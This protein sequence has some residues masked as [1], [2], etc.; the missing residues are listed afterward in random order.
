MNARQL[1]IVVIL[2][3]LM[4]VI[5]SQTAI[6]IA[7]IETVASTPTA[8]LGAT[9][10]WNFYDPHDASL[11]ELIIAADDAYQLDPDWQIQSI[12]YLYQWWGLADPVFNYQAITRT[13]T[14]FEANG[15]P[16]A[17][18]LV[19]EFLGRLS[20]LH[21]SQAILVGQDHTDDYPSWVL[22]ITG[23]DGQRIQLYSSSTANPNS[24]PWNVLSN[25]RLYAQYDGSMGEA[26][27]KLFPTEQGIPGASFYPGGREPDTLVFSTNGFPTQLYTGFV[28]LLPV[29]SSFSYHLDAATGELKGFV[30][31][32]S[33]I[34]E[35]GNMV[36]GTITS[37]SRVEVW[38]ADGSAV[39]CRV[40]DIP[41]NDPA[42]ARWYFTCM[43]GPLT[44]GQ[45]YH[46]PIQMV[47][48][49][50]QGERVTT[51]G[52]L[53]GL[54]SVEMEVQYLLPVPPEILTAMQKDATAKEFVAHHTFVYADYVA[55]TP[56]DEWQNGTFAGEALFAGQTELLG[57]T[58]RYTVGTPF[59]IEG[60]KLTYWSASM[61]KIQAMLDEIAAQALTRRVVAAVP[62]V[63]INLW[64]AEAG[65]RPETPFLMNAYP[66]QY[67]LGLATCGDVDAIRLPTADVPLR[68]FGFN[69]SWGFWR[70]DF[71]L[72]DNKVVVGSFDFWPGD[73]PQDS[74]SSLLLP[75][76][77]KIDPSAQFERIWVQAD[78]WNE[79]A[80]LTLYVPASPTLEQLD[81]YNRIV[82]QLPGLVNKQYETM[83]QANGLTFKVMD[84][85]TLKTVSCNSK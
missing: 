7:P 68:S 73:D 54:V 9:G 55:T 32:R 85:G 29:S 70:G 84:D 51:E 71:V 15:E 76:E 74:V 6:P 35:M 45:P 18:A 61:S 82:D 66:S 81:A 50:D 53:R 3:S 48:G 41:T 25:G 83:W 13:E 49:T 22:E 28:G 52:E 62:D 46:Y 11:P 44:V 26:I 40:D 8:S 72:L 1:I 36:I 10:V 42:G 56:S 58:V 78:A 69:S 12:E 20:N 2:V 31:G 59:A 4:A 17:A 27:G 14:G 37:L 34:A 24:A 63:V 75:D 77:F 5:A 60:G 39:D 65:E 16:V 64:Y 33:S 43:V 21:P 23:V 67:R 47:L 30:E 19:N 57:E 79:G 80:Q 38:R